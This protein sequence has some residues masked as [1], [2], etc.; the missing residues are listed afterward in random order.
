MSNNGDQWSGYMSQL[1]PL[2]PQYSKPGD[3]LPQQPNTLAREINKLRH[4]L[5]TAGIYVTTRGYNDGNGMKYYISQIDTSSKTDDPAIDKNLTDSALDEL[6][7]NNAEPAV[8]Q[9]EN[10][11]SPSEPVPE[12]TEEKEADESFL[13]PAINAFGSIVK[14][15]NKDVFEGGVKYENGY[16]KPAVGRYEP[17]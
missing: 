17:D 9:M 16:P 10:Q 12:V 1:L 13:T 2:L 6:L 15:K 7:P 11:F 5:E 8:K 3:Y 14:S 4:K